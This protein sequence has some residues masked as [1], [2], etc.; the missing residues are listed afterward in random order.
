M[1]AAVVVSLLALAVF[2]Y[3]VS[4]PLVRSSD[5]ERIPGAAQVQAFQLADDLDRSGLTFDEILRLARAGGFEPMPPPEAV[6]VMN[7][8]LDQ[9]RWY[10]L[11]FENDSDHWQAVILDLIWRV[12]NRSALYVPKSDGTWRVELNGGMVSRWDPLRSR[13]MAAFDVA[14]PPRET[15]TVY[16]N[17]SD[18]YR[19]PT[20]FQIWRNP[21]DFSRWERFESAKNFGYFSLC[22]GIVAYGFFLYAVLR[23]KVQLHFVLFALL[24]GAVQMVSSGLI[25]YLFV[26][27]SG[28]PF[29][30]LLISTLGVLALLNLCLFA[31]Y[32]LNTIGADPGLDRWMRRMQWVSCSPLLVMPLL[33]WPKFGLIYLQIFLVIAVV[34]VGFLVGASLRRWRRGSRSAPYFLLAFSPYFIGLLVRSFT[35][36]DVVNRDDEFRLIALIGNALCLIFLSFASGYR[37]RLALE[38]NLALQ[39]G[40]VGRLEEE[41]ESRTRKLKALSEQLAAA[42][43]QRD[44]LMAVIG[45]DLRGP[46]A[47]L[48]TLSD[49]LLSDP[50]SLSHEEMSEMSEEIRNLCTN[51]LEL[52][53][54]LLM[55]GGAQSEVWKLADSQLNVRQVLEAVWPLLESSAEAKA[56]ELRNLLPADLAVRTDE[57]LLQTLFRNLLANAIKFSRP[58]GVIEVGTSRPGPADG[59]V[60]IYVKDDGVGIPAAKLATLFKGTVVSS[61]GTQAEKG[62]GIGLMLCHDMLEAAG[63]E[64]RIESYEGVGT[65]AFFRLPRPPESVSPLDADPPEAVP[66]DSVDR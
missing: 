38:D 21:G 66:E 56:L 36:Q 19:L 44:R 53:N 24:L 48:Q 3:F 18:S 55:W 58:S 51:Q 6:P 34:V 5:A 49:M 29:T 23:Q 60:E 17:V 31:R 12:Y 32:F 2:I 57:Q 37:H 13:R 26:P 28:W 41:V 47:T 22:V 52:L 59:A 30:E 20:Q 8:R 4:R 64:L 39:A 11:D 33:F 35:A 63:G 25:F 62:A 7:D 61:P 16:L 50:E 27:P 1:V 65:T 42:V 40:H 10:R 54:N 9:D 46:M 14:L 45:H 43:V 15:L